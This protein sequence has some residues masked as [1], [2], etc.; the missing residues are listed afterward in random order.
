MIEE[1]SPSWIVIKFGGTSVADI[2]RWRNIAGIIEQRLSENLRPVIVCSAPSG[3]SNLLESLLEKAL[4]GDHETIFNQIQAIYQ[5]LAQAMAVDFSD[6]LQS[7]FDQL[8]RLVQGISLLGEVSARTQ[9]QIMAY[10]EIMLTALAA[11][12]LNS[13]GISTHWQDARELLVAAQSD[14][15]SHREF[16]S[17]YCEPRY[18]IDVNRRLSDVVEPVIITQGFIASNA[19]GETVLLGRG[20]SDTSAAYLAVLLNAIRCEIW[21]DVPGIY[22]ANPH[23]IP[24]ARFLKRLDYDE[25]QEIA[26]MG[27]KVLHPNC[28]APLKIQGIPLYVKYTPD[29]QREGTLISFEGDRTNVQIKSILTRY[30]VMLI[31]IETVR[32]WQQVGFLADVF[33]CF[34]KRGISIDLVSTSESSVTV[35]LDG[36]INNQNQCSIERLLNDLS[37]FAQA[38]VI[39]PCASIS[40]VGHNIR[41]ILHRLGF[42]FEVFEEQQIH[43][44]SQAAND[45]NLTFVV[46]EDQAQRLAQR[47]HNL[48]IEQTEASYY[49]NQSWVQE[50]GETSKTEESWWQLRRNKL[51]EVAAQDSPLYVYDENTLTNSINALKACDAIDQ[52][53]YSV[54]ANPHPQ[55]LQHFY[56]SGLNFECVSLEEVNHVLTLCPNIDRHRILFTPNFAP[57]EEYEKALALKIN[58]T[59]DNVYP[60][61]HWPDLFVDSEL[62]IRIDTG[63]GYGHHKHVVTCGSG[64]KFGI[65]LSKLDQLRKLIKQHRIKVVGLH[66]H[67][68]SGILD[69]QAWKGVSLQ[70]SELLADFPDASIIDI[71][72]GFGVV[73][74]PGQKPLDLVAVNA[75]LQAIKAT[76]PGISIWIE[77]GRFLVAQAGVLLARVTQI[78][79]KGDMQF[80]GIETGM[81]S[82]IRPALYGAYHE[83][84]NLSRLDEPKTQMVN[85]VGP[86]CETGDTLG[87]SRLIP[88]TQEGDFLLIANVGAYGH[89][90]SSHYNL[91]VPAKEYFLHTLWCN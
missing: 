60:L 76:H 86:I 25:A 16:L 75:S 10:G 77:P 67:S 36:N 63:E 71:G 64:S 34:K 88:K 17:A 49:F 87:Y 55:I 47:L 9:A 53:F 65:P 27:G 59:L 6:C 29:P 78:K 8:S 20:G 24:E 70:L 58:V 3:V 83:I 38:K 41:A 21:T 23:Q 50:F 82:L 62:F 74:K 44:L 79:Q 45:L 26:S 15:H 46:D 11:A 39:G 68:G 2:D 54:K 42:A 32:M 89:C 80:V 28:I 18:D 91:R 37:Q 30:G 69:S 56:Q 1:S 66:A 14:G 40:L 52:V 57:R 61:E 90:M 4:Q 12:Y 84:V 73:E 22:T 19:Q 13:V 35:S 51:L 31:S 5:T 72:G 7:Y 33:Q 81:N 48:L 85:V 43:L